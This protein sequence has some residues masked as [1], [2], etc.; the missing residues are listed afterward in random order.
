MKKGVIFLLTVAI[1]II[2]IV[3]FYSIALSPV[4]K[5][6]DNLEKEYEILGSLSVNEFL[7]RE[8]VQILLEDIKNSYED[9]ASYHFDKS[10]C[11][12]V[13]EARDVFDDDSITVNDSTTAADIEDWDS[14][15][16]INLIV[17]VEKAFNIRFNIHYYSTDS[18]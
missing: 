9:I 16:H 8:S 13:K 14:L 6:S 1:I 4:K 11:Q 17:S 18:R 10:L 12:K 5:A 2:A 3:V 15:E 7:G